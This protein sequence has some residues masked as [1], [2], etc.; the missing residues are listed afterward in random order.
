MKRD[1]QIEYS[2]KN[3]YLTS[4]NWHLPEWAKELVE[5]YQSPLKRRMKSDLEEVATQ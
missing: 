2:F 4:L 1:Y 5:L 3:E